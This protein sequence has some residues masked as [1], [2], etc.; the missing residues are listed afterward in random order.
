MNAIVK[1]KKT[2]RSG[3]R[4]RLQKRKAEILKL[5]FATNPPLRWEATISLQ[6][7]LDQIDQAQKAKEKHST[8]ATTFKNIKLIDN[9]ISKDTRT[10]KAQLSKPA[11]KCPDD[12][13]GPLDSAFCRY[14]CKHC[15]AADP[16]IE[17]HRTSNN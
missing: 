10:P 12:C 6:A 8:S 15:T 4:V 9:T 17:Q 2:G 5:L 14:T 11:K 3:I 16:D 7:E 13:E 1:K